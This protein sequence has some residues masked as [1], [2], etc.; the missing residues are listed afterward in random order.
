MKKTD[1]RVSELKDRSLEI[2]HSEEQS[3][4]DWERWAEPQ[5][6]VR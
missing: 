3:K 1:W 4:K 6:T 5:R 2:V